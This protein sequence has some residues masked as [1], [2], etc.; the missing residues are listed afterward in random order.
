MNKKLLSAL[1]ILLNSLYFSAQI[2]FTES[3]TSLGITTNYF[4]NASAFLTGG[5]SFCD[6]DGD[7]WD[8]LSFATEAG[9]TVKFFKNNSGLKTTQDRFYCTNRR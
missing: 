7:G 1:I 2:S 9:N 5:V 3:A 8:D 4:G 6:F